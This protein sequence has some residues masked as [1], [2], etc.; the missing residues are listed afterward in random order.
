M[1]ICFPSFFFFG[2]FPVVV[3]LHVGARRLHRSAFAQF[4]QGLS[5]SRDPRFP[6]TFVAAPK[7]LTLPET[8]I[9]HQNPLVSL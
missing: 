1:M 6:V 4:F 5:G 2:I 9:A 7:T 8:N 3:V